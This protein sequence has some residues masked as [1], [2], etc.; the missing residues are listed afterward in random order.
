[1]VLSLTLIRYNPRYVSSWSVLVS[2]DN[3]NYAKID[4]LLICLTH[5]DNVSMEIENHAF[6]QLKHS[7][8]SS[9]VLKKIDFDKTF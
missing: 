8:S 7:F 3:I 9:K 2:Y 6:D 1:M 5:K 4:A